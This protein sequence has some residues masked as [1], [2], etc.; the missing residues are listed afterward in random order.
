VN[1]LKERMKGGGGANA[2][3]TLPNSH[4]TTARR[5]FSGAWV[6][7]A[8][9]SVKAT[10]CANLRFSQLSAARFENCFCL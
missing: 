3:H 1:F 4:S 8:S 9:K 5:I 6:G 2:F 7:Q 10:P